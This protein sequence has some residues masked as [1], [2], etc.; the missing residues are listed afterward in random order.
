MGNRT[1]LDN[2]LRV[3]SGQVNALGGD[4]YGSD[5]PICQGGNPGE[6]ISRFLEGWRTLAVDRDRTPDEARSIMEMEDGE[7]NLHQRGRTRRQSPFSSAPREG[8]EQPRQFPG[9]SRRLPPR[10]KRICWRRT[11][12]L[13]ADQEISRA[14]GAVK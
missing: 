7:V 6:Q 13:Q 11:D 8:P 14:K 5:S 9:R 4:C 12:Q 10:P 1:S 2:G 3:S